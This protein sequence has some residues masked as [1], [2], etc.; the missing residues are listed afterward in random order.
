MRRMNCCF[1]L[2]ASICLLFGW[3]DVYSQALPDANLTYRVGPTAGK[4]AFIPKTTNNVIFAYAGEPGQPFITS[5]GVFA[6]KNTPL[7]PNNALLVG[8]FDIA[9]SVAKGTATA[10]L[11]NWAAGTPSLDGDPRCPGDSS[12]PCLTRDL[13]LTNIEIYNNPSPDNPIWKTGSP[14]GPF[15]A[16]VESAFKLDYSVPPNPPNAPEAEVEVATFHYG[17]PSTATAGQTYIINLPKSPAGISAV[18]GNVTRTIVNSVKIGGK[19]ASPDTLQGGSIQIVVKPTVKLL[20]AALANVDGTTVCLKWQI[21]PAPTNNPLDPVTAPFDFCYGVHVF[22]DGVDLTKK[23]FTTTETQISAFDFCEISE[24]N[25]Y[26]VAIRIKEDPSCQCDTDCSSGCEDCDGQIVFSNQLAVSRIPHLLSEI[27]PNNWPYFR[28]LT[29]LTVSSDYAFHQDCGLPSPSFDGPFTTS[30]TACS[31][32]TPVIKGNCTDPADLCCNY[33]TSAKVGSSLW[34][35]EIS[36]SD[37]DPFLAGNQPFQFIYDGKGNRADTQIVDPFTVRIWF[38]GSGDGSASAFANLPG[39]SPKS[40]DD[41]LKPRRIP[42]VYRVS[43]VVV[44]P[45]KNL[46]D[47]AYVVARSQSFPLNFGFRRG[48]SNRNTAVTLSDVVNLL[49]FWGSGGNVIQQLDC[50]ADVNDSD[51]FTL[52]DAVFLIRHVAFNPGGPPPPQ[53]FTTDDNKPYFG[54]DGSGRPPND[55]AIANNVLLRC[56]HYCPCFKSEVKNSGG[57][58]DRRTEIGCCVCRENHFDPADPQSTSCDRYKY[59]P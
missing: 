1:F 41:P 48:D 36:C 27:S 52:A 43:L 54:M 49:N 35:I 21:D 39:V 26:Q 38:P 22:R 37:T 34:K 50:A 57:E 3:T 53:P 10:N 56:F 16:A 25:S 46:G 14:N 15:D 45:T 8:G 23:P 28:P 29:D 12:L 58:G 6:S 9:F 33:T 13:G 18:N 47:A 5:I 4:R 7:T 20:S 11:V 32:S 40:P 59:D 55:F 24:T 30:A 17:I 2:G 31:G 42:S 44:D 51:T 19:D